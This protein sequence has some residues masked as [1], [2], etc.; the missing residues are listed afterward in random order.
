MGRRV[1]DYMLPLLTL[2]DKCAYQ[3]S[4]LYERKEKQ[5]IYHVVNYSKVV[6]SWIISMVIST[7]PLDCT[8]VHGG[9]ICVHVWKGKRRRG[10]GRR[11]NNAVVVNMELPH[12]AFH[13]SLTTIADLTIFATCTNITSNYLGWSSCSE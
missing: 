4:K 1:C 9:Y 8:C 6:I 5:S 3:A 11:C 2:V 7:F 10:R 13:R 12:F